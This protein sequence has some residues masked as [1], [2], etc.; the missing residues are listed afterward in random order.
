MVSYHCVAFC[1]VHFHINNM[2]PWLFWKC[3]SLCPWPPCAAAVLESPA[4]SILDG[5]NQ[6]LLTA[7]PKQQLFEEQLHLA[8]AGR[9]DLNAETL[10]AEEECPVS[11]TADNFRE[12]FPPGSRCFCWFFVM[13]WSR[14]CWVKISQIKHFR[15]QK[16]CCEHDE[17]LGSLSKARW[18]PVH[19][20]HSY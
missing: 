15:L 1:S 20:V 3:T 19:S 14:I 6:R 13:L 9:A 2:F 17:A 5:S 8:V 10:S 11:R 7:A 16:G 4:Q 18:I 12:R